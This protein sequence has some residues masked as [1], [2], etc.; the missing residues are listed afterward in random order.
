MS[1]TTLPPT[2]AAAVGYDTET[3]GPNVTL[4]T[5]WLPYN[6]FGSNASSVNATQNGDGSVT[7]S[8]GGNTYN[9][10]LATA[11]VG[12]NGYV[13]EVFGG[14]FYAQA[15][16]SVPG[17][18]AGL[19]APGQNQFPAFWSNTIAGYLGT[20]SDVEVDFMEMD[21]MSPGQYGY[22][23]INWNT[24]PNQAIGTSEP[25]VNTGANLSQSNTYG[26]LWVPATAST[27][28]EAEFFFNGQQVGSVSWN[29]GQGPF[30][31]IDGQQL[32]LIL[33]AGANSPMTVSNVQVWQTSSANDSIN[34]SPAPFIQSSPPGGGGGSGTFIQSPNNTVVLA[35]SSAAITDA[36]GNAWTITAGGQVA[37]NGVADTTTNGV[38]ELA[39]EKGLIWQENGAKL[40]WS[41][42][43]PSAA[44]GPTGGTATSPV[45]VA[46]PP[47]P[48]PNNT[49]VMA[50]S[51]SAITDA[52]GNAWT[53]TAGGQ[54]AVNG[55]ADTSTNGVIGQIGRASCRERV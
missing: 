15:T 20:G 42:S 40:W 23:M 43:S 48:S 11:V 54:V 35:G 9:G 29:Q 4:G 8:G 36:S 26:F 16:I 39:Y 38:I 7:I 44:W 12:G 46:A 33:G 32:T 5:N 1:A 17:Q 51:S 24:S 47:S 25:T 41:K 27:P 30:S 49:V 3:F 37:V 53:I 31:A 45:P 10:Q 28:G 22:D 14:G 18:T 55:V 6:F 2:P 19:W 34:G 52:S 13:G 50:G 21:M